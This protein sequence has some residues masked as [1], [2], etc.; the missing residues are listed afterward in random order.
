MDGLY[1]KVSRDPVHGEIK[2][3]P[4]EILIVD[5]LPVQRL[6]FLSQLAGAE[7]VYPG[8]THTRFLHSLGTMHI[9]GMYAQHLFKDPLKFT[10]L[11]LAGLLHDVGHGP[12]SHQ[13]DEVIF[14]EKLGI[15]EGHD[16]YRK[17]I[18]LEIL[19]EEVDRRL[20]R[21]EDERVL[22]GI[23]SQLQ[24]LGLSDSNIV[25]SVFQLLKDVVE[26]YESE[27]IGSVEFNIVQGPLGADRLDFVLRDSYFSG[28]RHFGTG[29][30][31]R[32]VN[33]ALIKD[34]NLL[35]NT[36]VIDD[37]YTVL[38]GR[39]M[40]YKNVYF[41]K[42]SRAVDLMIQRILRKAYRILKLEERVKDLKDFLMLTDHGIFIEILHEASKLVEKEELTPEE[43]E[44]ME[45]FETLHR[46]IR[47]DLW[48]LLIERPFTTRGIDPAVVSQGVAEDILN[49]MKK[50]I[51][52]VL[53]K[54]ELPEQ[55]RLKLIELLEKF[56]DFF[57]VDTPYK[58]TL[59][60]PEEFTVNKVLLYDG[61]N[62]EVLSFEEFEA[63]NPAYRLLSNNLIQLVR[64]YTVEDVRGLLEKYNIVV[65]TD[66]EL[67]TRW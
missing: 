28:T 32:I 2:L 9:C 27:T 10:L 19:P 44:L 58:L 3:M 33:H 12:Y 1:H 14:K 36:K 16:E 59:A 67:T 45:A 29:A 24:V 7:F 11:R 30:L 8:A 40:M 50:R 4:L 41:H 42:T 35:Y 65:E 62:D 26:I 20:K 47:R 64:V 5:T 13:F 15:T 31:D 43:E 60:H 53:T 22:E 49:R 66:V 39:F 57:V 38:F 21:I 46:L 51:R 48:K 17:R 52:E 18:I 61:K 37:I 54:K 55:D 25:E 6:R 23:R 34:G 63:K 56:E